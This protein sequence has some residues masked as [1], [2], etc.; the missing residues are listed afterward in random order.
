MD[1]RRRH[2]RTISSVIFEITDL[3]GEALR[4]LCVYLNPIAPATDESDAEQFLVHRRETQQSEMQQQ[5]TS[6]ENTCVV[7]KSLGMSYYFICEHLLRIQPMD[8]DID[9]TEEASTSQTEIY[10]EPLPT[11][12]AGSEPWHRNLP[13][14]W[15]PIITRDMQRQAEVGS[16][17]I[18]FFISQSF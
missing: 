14:D 2:A 16:V 11:V 7:S 5:Q 10:D 13:T 3:A 4:F 15:L 1:E 6:S 18:K 8:T 9:I 17:H 12:V